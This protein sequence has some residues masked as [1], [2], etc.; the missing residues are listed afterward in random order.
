[1]D[2]SSFL[3]FNHLMGTDYDKISPYDEMIVRRTAKTKWNL[4]CLCFAG[5]SV[6]LSILLLVA[7]GLKITNVYL[8]VMALSPVALAAF[9]LT[10]HFS[11]S[12]LPY[13][14][15]YLCIYVGLLESFCF[16]GI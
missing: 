2:K 12:H 1:M 14:G 11:D 16:S 13:V 10:A 9:G 8:F 15:G 7:F 5:F 4:T 6:C 3:V